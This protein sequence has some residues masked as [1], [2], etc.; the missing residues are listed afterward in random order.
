MKKNHFNFVL[1]ATLL[2]VVFLSAC[3]EF[4]LE[5]IIGPYFGHDHRSESIWVRVEYVISITVFVTISLII[6]AMIGYRL[7]DNHEKLTEKIKR[8]AE[9]DYLTKLYNRRK[10][11]EVVE[12]EILRSRRYN[13]T[14]AV[15]LLDIDN[16]KKTNDTF[17]HN[18]GDKLLVEIANII[19]QTIRESDMAGR[20]GGEE[21]LVFCPQTGG[22]GAFALA[23]KLRAN[24]EKHEFE[25]I[26]YK[27]ASF[28]AAQIE[29]GDT[30]QGLI[31]RAD[32][33]LYEAKNS[34]KNMVL[35]SA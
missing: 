3:W 33:A 8:L 30:V 32:E 1:I 2:S 34:G 6:P 13:S 25:E 5:D 4:W 29:H 23:E 22:D 31:S 9:E 11:H 20:W 17:G 24:I 16:F 21:F 26:G 28:G 12:N 35:V 15:I 7:I 14:F 18:V 27:T 19:R 10:I